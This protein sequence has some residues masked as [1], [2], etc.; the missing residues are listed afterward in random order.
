MPDSQSFGQ[1]LVL[2]IHIIVKSHLGKHFDVTVA[3]TDTL[4]IPEQGRD[5]DE[6]LG[7]IERPYPPQLATH[8][9]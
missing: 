2:G 7:W 5:D 1:Q 8:Y 6:V 4:P 3:W 9:H